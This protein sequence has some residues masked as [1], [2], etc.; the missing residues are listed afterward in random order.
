MWPSSRIPI[1]EE[2]VSSASFEL[3]RIFRK[4]SIRARICS[5]DSNLPRVI[6]AAVEQ[7][8]CSARVPANIMRALPGIFMLLAQPQ[9][10]SGNSARWRSQISSRLN[11]PGVSHPENLAQAVGGCRYAGKCR[12]NPASRQRTTVAGGCR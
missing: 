12:G 2:S 11:F 4:R 10:R 1:A 7:S 3:G 6:S 5:L 9:G 8:Q